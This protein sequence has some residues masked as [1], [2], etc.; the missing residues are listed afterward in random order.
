VLIFTTYHPNRRKGDEVQ[1]DVGAFVLMS[2]IAVLAPILAAQLAHWVPVPLAV[3]EI[4]LG[5]LLGPQ[6]FGLGKHGEF[7]D[8]LSDLGLAT[9]MFLAGYEIDF[10]R[11]SG[12]PLRRAAIGWLVGLGLSLAV[13]LL[14]AD[15]ASEAVYIGAAMATTALGTILPIVRDAEL[16]DTPFGR[17]ITAV[18]SVGEFGPIVAVAL[19]LSGRSPGRSAVTLLL[20]AAVTALAIW[21]ASHTRET[22]RMR[23]LVSKTLHS[24]GQFAVRMMI[25]VLALL[26]YLAVELDL[27]TLLG[28]FTAGIIGRM[29]LSSTSPLLQQSVMSKLEAVGFGFL[30]PVFF[31]NTGLDFDLDALTAHASTLALLPLF[32][33]LFLLLRGGPVAL[34]AE[35]RTSYTDRAV[36]GMFGATQLPMVVAITTIGTEAGKLDSGTAAALVGA[37][38]LSVLLFPLIALRLRGETAP[39]ARPGARAESW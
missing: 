13:A 30:V 10:G 24:S 21:R 25:C 6:G 33:M 1:Q 35:P 5:L 38:M 11:I 29:L 28:A 39:V 20:F 32:L 37:G 22:A 8:A 16:L 2:V 17:T 9:L 27:D 4:V 15:S 18:G 31:I 34:L 19:F 3:F 23:S 26:V 7:I 36:L 14:I 12:S